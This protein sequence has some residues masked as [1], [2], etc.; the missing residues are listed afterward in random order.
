M[1]NVM[2]LP[3]T[4]VL[5]L[6][7]IITFAVAWLQLQVTVNYF[8]QTNDLFSLSDS[9]MNIYLVNMS[10]SEYEVRDMNKT[11]AVRL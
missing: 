3:S 9:N 2:V 7:D 6:S 4:K 5:F 1:V 8:Y 10:A 11:N